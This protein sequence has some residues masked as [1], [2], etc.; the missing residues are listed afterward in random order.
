MGRHNKVEPKR[1]S[2]LGA[3]TGIFLAMLA[4]I[5][6]LTASGI[7]GSP[8]AQ[9]KPPVVRSILPGELKTV[10]PTTRATA[11]PV[12]G[13]QPTGVQRPTQAPTISPSP[14]PSPATPSVGGHVNVPPVGV[15]TDIDVGVGLLGQ[16]DQTVRT[17]G[18]TVATVTTPILDT[19]EDL[20]TK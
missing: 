9:D 20:L 19:V 7:T 12:V 11:T 6:V 1:V 3:T 18:D 8:F 15:D 16:V 4:T 5:G 10:V 13:S 17:V 14:N 2:F